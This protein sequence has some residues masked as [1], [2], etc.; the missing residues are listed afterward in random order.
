MGEFM[1]D[2]EIH[3]YIENKLIATGKSFG[4]M[5]SVPY[6]SELVFNTSMQ[7]Y[8]EIITDPSYCD[9]SIVMTYP[10]IGNYGINKDD[11]ESVIPHLQTL[12]VKEY[13][14][15]PSNFRNTTSLDSFLEQKK[16]CGIHGVDTRELARIV[17][18][19]GAIKCLISNEKL[20]QEQIDKLFENELPTDQIQ[21]V[22]TKAI[23][24]FPNSN[25]PRIILIDYGYKKNI[26]SN[27]LTRGC[28][29]IL[30]PFD[31]DAQTIRDLNPKGIVLSNGPGD[32]ESISSV[33]P[34][35]AELQKE[36]PLFGI[37]MGHEIF[38]MANGA[39]IRKMKFGH[40][41]GNHPVKDFDRNR[42]YITSQNHGYCV[43]E[44]SIP[45][46]D[47]EITQ[48]NLNDKTIEGLRHKTLPAMSVQYHPEASPGPMDTRYLF[49]E[50]IEKLK[51]G[52]HAS[53]S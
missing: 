23:T 25:G 11:S 41:G 14:K 51:G 20:A 32:P 1:S 9:Q 39:G 12:I 38:A 45:K 48:I 17:R 52:T 31:T 26:L 34:T 21:R 18:S 53:K 28:D 5:P 24:H 6:L 27:L 16:I 33:I 43:D 49:D 7:G 37:C 30:V 4:A 3:I 22:S 36:Y 10:L 42:V 44:E 13:C 46:T 40:R 47:L 50:F 35:V 29:V 8:Q 15:N 2:K 19:K